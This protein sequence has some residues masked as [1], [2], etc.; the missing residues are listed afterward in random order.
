MKGFVHIIESPS[1]ADLLDG[2][3]EGKALGEAL[4]LAEIS[5]CYNLVSTTQ[6]LTTALGDKL[7]EAVNKYEM[8]PILHLSLHGNN[9]GIALTD[10]TF[11]TWEDLIKLL[12]PLVTAVNGG[13]LICMSSCFGSSGCRMAM[14]AEQDPPFWALIGHTGEADWSD[15]AVGYITFYHQFFK[16][17]SVSDC[18]EIMR[19]ASGD[20]NFMVWSGQYLKE[21]WARYISQY[22]TTQ[23]NNAFQ[24]AAHEGQG[25]LSGL[26]QR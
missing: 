16:G 11:I 2:R 22:G 17:R 23:L 6:S 26:L 5:Y 10:G 7:A 18:L 24:N 14:H 3:T 13:L 25:L 15:S 1:D 4:A 20:S 19:I 9:E 12:T 8:P 21:D